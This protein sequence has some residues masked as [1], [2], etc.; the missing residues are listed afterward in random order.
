MSETLQFLI[1][2]GYS[3]LFAWVFIEQAGVP[4]PSAPILLAAGALA[5]MHQTSLAMA[6]VLSLIATLLADALWYWLGARLGSRVLRFL[7][8]ISI[9]PDSCVRRT[10]VSFERQGARLLIVAK[11]IPGLSAMA[12]PLA[13]VI[14]MSWQRFVL[15]DAIGALLWADSFLVTGYVFSGELERVAGHMAFLGTW[16][17]VIL[18]GAFAV[19]IAQKF[20]KRRRFLRKL[21]IGRI[22]PEELKKKL[23]EGEDVVIV[24]LRHALEF[25]AEPET[26]PGSVRMDAADLEEALEVIPRDREI[27][28]FCNCPNE[29]TA[30]QMALLLRSK[31]ITRIRPLAEGIAGWRSRG[32]PL[33]PR[34][35]G[36]AML[37]ASAPGATESF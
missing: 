22:A 7:C 15:F 19:Y 32:F 34:Q 33:A 28:L 14:R 6:V 23:D 31:G 10:E 5:G 36:G 37:Q 30:A 18:I 1:R 17:I 11:F 12:P 16:L 25:D 35:I 20:I 9:E 3:L 21:R 26:I 24:D 8:R 2:H 29:A 13:G 27:V 4:I